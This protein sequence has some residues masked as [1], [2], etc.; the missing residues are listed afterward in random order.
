MTTQ[1]QVKDFAKANGIIAIWNAEY[2]EWAI[3]RRGDRPECDYC[4]DDNSDALDQC[5]Y[6]AGER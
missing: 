6:L 3:R 2:K 4:T 1:K 5:K